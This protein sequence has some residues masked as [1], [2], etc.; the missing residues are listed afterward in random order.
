[1]YGWMQPESAG[2]SHGEQEKERRRNRKRERERKARQAQ[3]QRLFLNCG[4]I[5]SFLF[6]SCS[7]NAH[8]R[9][10]GHRKA[11]NLWDI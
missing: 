1:M 11:C 7:N 5:F 3:L 8:L 4:Q 6:F 2:A 10:A 9:S